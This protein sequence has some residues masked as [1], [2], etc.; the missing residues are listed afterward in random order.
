[1]VHPCKS[2]EPELKSSYYPLDP[3][4]RRDEEPARRLGRSK[5]LISTF[6]WNKALFYCFSQP[7][8]LHEVSQNNKVFEKN[9]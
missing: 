2:R 1:M 9:S 7:L 8:V 4:L 3:C 5:F 6:K